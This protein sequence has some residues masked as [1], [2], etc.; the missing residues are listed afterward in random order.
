MH[1]EQDKFYISVS[2][3]TNQARLC[4]CTGITTYIGSC[5][6]IILGKTSLIQKCSSSNCYVPLTQYTFETSLVSS[7]EWN[8]FTIEKSNG[9][10]KVWKTSQNKQILS[11]NDQSYFRTSYLLVSSIGSPGYWKLHDYEFMATNKTFRTLLGEDM[12][13]SDPYFCMAIFVAMCQQCT[14][15][16]EVLYKTSSTG[17]LKMLEDTEIKPKKVCK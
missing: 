1:L 6:L 12:K 16:F 4:F 15:R 2:I 5:Y 17:R 8:H 7:Q 3:R 10:F 11:Y 14:L 9:Q 13:I